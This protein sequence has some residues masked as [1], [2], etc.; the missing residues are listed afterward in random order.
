MKRPNLNFLRKKEILILITLTI[1]ALIVRLL[2]ISQENGLWYDE[3]LTVVFA[4]AKTPLDILKTLLKY[5]FHM[6]LYYLYLWLWTNIF[7]TSDIALRLSSALFG[8]ANIPALYYLGKTYSDKKLGTWLAIVGAL[9]PI[10]IYYSRE[11]RFYSIL[12]FLS[13]VS[14]IY[15]LKLLDKFDFKKIVFWGIINLSILYIY[16]L[17][18]VFTAAQIIPL[19]IKYLKKEEFKSLSKFLLFFLFLSLPYFSLLIYYKIQSTNVM[20]DPFAFGSFYGLKSLI[21][22]ANDFF[23]PLIS[24]I[25]S[26]DFLTIKKLLSNKADTISF[27]IYSLPTLFMLLGIMLNLKPLTKNKKLLSLF[28]IAFS[29]IS[30]EALSAYLGNFVI[31]TRYLIIV[32]PILLLIAIDGLFKNKNLAK[33]SLISILTIYSLNIINFQNTPAFKDRKGGLKIPAGKITQIGFKS[34]DYI[35]YPTGDKLLLKYLP[36]AKT[37]EFEI[38]SILYLDKT[39]QEAEKIFDKNLIEKTTKK[40]STKNLT[41]YLKNPFPSEIMTSYINLEISKIPRNKTLF[42]LEE[43]EISTKKQNTIPDFMH[44]CDKTNKKLSQSELFY[45][46]Y[47][48]I[49]VDLNYILENNKN[50]E[51][52]HT[53]NFSALNDERIRWKIIVYKKDN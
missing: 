36:D 48:K 52:I 29:F 22:V 35:L 25:Y 31:L 51:K 34:Q 42:V 23:S 15:F 46:T 20:I 33:I 18:M 6:P 11:V 24:G 44:W 4:T 50:L 19:I 53:E 8:V 40:N 14:I 21:I 10:M 37:I 41:P 5:D 7:G 26:L 13:T 45:L 47:S 16:T 39:K 1:I 32:L 43:K 38:P 9:N 3:M 12:L 2:N 28:F 27:I 17:G 49:Y 30:V